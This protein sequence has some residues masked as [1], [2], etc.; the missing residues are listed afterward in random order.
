MKT[1]NNYNEKKEAKLEKERRA[2]D[3]RILGKTHQSIADELEV[4][5]STVSKMLSR[6]SKRAKKELLD[7][8]VN[9]KIAQITQLHYM[10]EELLKAWERS[11][12]STKTVIKKQAQGMPENGKPDNKM[13]VIDASEIS[14]KMADSDGDPR[15]LDLAMKAMAEI[16]KIMGVDTTITNEDTAITFIISKREIVDAK[17]TD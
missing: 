6:L 14:I 15:Y 7:D 17:S 8:V 13:I 16:R 9:E 1:Q 10:I 2:W 5:R 3:L 11:K 4:E 12:E